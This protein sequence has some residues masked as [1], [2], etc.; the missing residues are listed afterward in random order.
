MSS[1]TIRRLDPD[2]KERLRIRA[3]RHGHSM[4][5]EVRQILQATLARPEPPGAPDF[6]ERIHARFAAI[7]GVELELPPRDVGRPPPTFD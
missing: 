6:Y 3:A 2:L 4:E 5:A 7:G 1:I